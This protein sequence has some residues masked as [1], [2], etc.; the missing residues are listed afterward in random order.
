MVLNPVSF[1]ASEQVQKEPE[2]QMNS[3][4]RAHHGEHD[5]QCNNSA[6]QPDDESEQ[7]PGVRMLLGRPGPPYHPSIFRAPWA[8]KMIANT[9]QAI[10]TI[11]S[12]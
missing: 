8:K 12:A 4:N 3:G 6:E 11:Q 9:I 2:S 10:A 5:E 1:L 7:F